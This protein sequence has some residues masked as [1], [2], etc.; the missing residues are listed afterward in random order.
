MERR[1][2]SITTLALLSGFLAACSAA[3]PE[4]VPIAFYKAVDAGDVE[5]AMS[6]VSFASFTAD[7]MVAAKGKVQMVIGSAQQRF[8]ANDGFDR[9]EIVSVETAEDGNAS[10]VYT[11]LFFKNGKDMPDKVLLVKNEDGWKIKLK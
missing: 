10:M 11:K 8:K 6:Y 9:V 1:V 3:K 2:F 4:E 5:K 7:E